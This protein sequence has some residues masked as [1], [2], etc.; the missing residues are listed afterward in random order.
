MYYFVIPRVYNIR[1]ESVQLLIPQW[2]ALR[3]V[4]TQLAIVTIG[5]DSDSHQTHALARIIILAR[6]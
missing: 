6:M 5:V 2:N 4:M 1:E 3:Q